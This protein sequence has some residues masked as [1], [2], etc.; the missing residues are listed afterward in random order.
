[1][2]FCGSGTRGHSSDEYG[3]RCVAYD[4]HDLERRNPLYGPWV[5]W[6]MVKAEGWLAKNGSKWKSMPD[7]MFR[8]RAAAFWQRL[9]APE[10]ALGL[11]TTEEAADIPAQD[12]A[13]LDLNPTASP[14]EVKR[15]R[16][17]S[18]AG[19]AVAEKAKAEPR[20]Y[21]VADEEIVTD[22]TDEDDTTET[23]DTPESDDQPT[24]NL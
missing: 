4:I 3:V 20:P 10:L 13:Y 18:I 9:Y 7:M 1:M 23:P 15:S 16:L 24:L 22:N 14:R 17:S 2:R 12:T 21:P 11:M 19:K 6:A 8:Y 5:T